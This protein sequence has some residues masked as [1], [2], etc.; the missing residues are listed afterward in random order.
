MA[1][2]ISE[3]MK[4][5]TPSVVSALASS[6][7]LGG[8]AVSSVLGGAVPGILGALINRGSTPSGGAAILG[9][10]AG[11]NPAVMSGLAGALGGNGASSMANEGIS[12]LTSLVGKNGISSLT[13]AV[14]GNAGVSAAAGGPLMGLAAQMVM[15]SL[16]KNASGMDGAGLSALLGSQKSLVQQ[17]L[18]SSL[19]DVLGMAG[20]ASG[21]AGMAGS[22]MGAASTAA[23]HATSG[24]SNA[25]SKVQASMPSA[26][27][28]PTAPDVGGMGWLKYAIPVAL[29]ALG[30]WYFGMR[31][32]V[33]DVKMA[34]KPAAAAVTTMAPA[35]MMVGDID[36]GKN[37]TGAFGNL[38]GALGGVTDVASAKAALPKLTEAGTA[39]SAVS[40]MAAKFS[41][42]Q[43][44]S[45]AALVNSNMP[46]LT[47]LATKV[48]GNAEV[49]GVLKPVLDTIMASLSGMAK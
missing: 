17:A 16:A 34:A 43:K 9:Q 26:P 22:A 27:S 28:M 10:L 33:D 30:A 35:N 14:M 41:A 38:T 5:A 2:I 49:A 44:T 36:I 6:T 18:P 47:G 45:V 48:Q 12:M 32:D 3:V 4:M 7:G 29:I 42:E 37:L 21:V 20:M 19:G 13:N 11:V 39:I 15:G 23:S 31:K 25:A 1:D 40:G 46:A 8:S 24:M